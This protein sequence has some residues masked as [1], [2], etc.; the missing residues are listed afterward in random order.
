MRLGVW[1]A[2]V[3]L[4][5]TGCSGASVSFGPRPVELPAESLRQMEEELTEAR[6]PGA[7]VIICD[8]DR[9]LYENYFGE[10]S[11]GAQPFLLGSLSKSFTAL[12]VMQL[13]E[14]G[15][16]NLDAPLAEYHPDAR[17]AVTI[18]ELLNQTSGFGTY[19]TLG[20][21]ES[22]PK[23]GSHVYA[24]VNYSLLGKVVEAA[25]G[26]SFADYLERY[27][28]GPLGMAGTSARTDE[29]RARELIQGYR[30]FL[31]LQSPPLPF[32]QQEKATGFRRP[33]DT[34]PQL[35]LIWR[36]ICRCTCGAATASWKKSI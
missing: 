1:M 4:L 21:Y 29:T 5:I 25:S 19:Q 9:I 12:C 30:N 20:N 34:Y 13:V 26:L 22:G 14:Q 8:K 35:L 6:F 11:S 2:A 33:Q 28:S 10:C 17:A 31:A 23:R 3:L 27:V 18:R 36:D 32:F 15:K 16:I 7:A 24:N